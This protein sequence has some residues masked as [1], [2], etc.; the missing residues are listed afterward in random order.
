MELTTIQFKIN[1]KTY[2]SRQAFIDDMELIVK[3]CL[4]YNGEDTCKFL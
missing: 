2:K 3:N 4:T 1:S